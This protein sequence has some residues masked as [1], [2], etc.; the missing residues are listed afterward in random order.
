MLVVGTVVV[1]VA[2]TLVVLHVQSS[3]AASGDSPG[4]TST[5]ILLGSH[6]PLTGPAAPGY[7]EV[8]TAVAAFFKYVDAHGGVYGR[9]IVFDYQDDAY[10]PLRT[11]KVTQELVARDKIFAMVAGLGTATHQS[12]VNYLTQQGV[13]DLFVESG[14]TC[15]NDPDNYPDTFGYFPDYK[16][17]GKILGQ[18]VDTRFP[19]S[20]VAY[21]LQDDDLGQNSGE[22][23]NQV[24][25]NSQVVTQQSYDTN[26]LADGLLPQITAAR[27]AGATVVV[28]FG[29]Q[30]AVALSLLAA[31]QLDYHPTFVASNVGSDTSALAS[32]IT[33]YSRGAANIALANGMITDSYIPSPDDLTD[34]WVQLFRTV[35][36]TYDTSEPFDFTT[37]SGMVLAYA[38]YQ[39]LEAAGPNLTRQSLLNALTTKGS[40][41][42]GPNV[43]PYGF[44]T[45]DHDGMLGTQVGTVSNGRL[46]LSGPVFV[47]DD[48]DAPV[49]KY[50]ATET[51]PP[52][53]F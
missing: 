42:H 8:S 13:P 4:V 53:T 14:C 11:L 43:A 24:I 49:T 23:L 45:T 20:K 38:T 32:L 19:S 39:A 21:L 36:D 35:H 29:I 6:Q 5:E 27:Q 22:G 7:Q 1:L 28:V 12:V 51:L 37:V 40:S 47:T 48:K 9:S 30:A 26:Q 25:P 3:D 34:P 50:T 52:T 31:A 2:A 46:L 16:I 18:Y 41:F 15:F 10:D 33:Q 17:E 44:S